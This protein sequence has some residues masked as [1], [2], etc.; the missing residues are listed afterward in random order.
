MVTVVTQLVLSKLEL[1]S[2]VLMAP[3]DSLGFHT[4]ALR[5]ATTMTEELLTAMIAQTLVAI[6]AQSNLQASGNTIKLT[7]PAKRF[8]EM[9]LWLLV[10]RRNA[11]MEQPMQEMSILEMDATGVATWKIQLSLGHRMQTSFGRIPGLSQ[12]RPQ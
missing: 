11:K 12:M 7:S 9:E 1:L 5:T 3:L 4:L 8:A 10:P 2:P 6:V